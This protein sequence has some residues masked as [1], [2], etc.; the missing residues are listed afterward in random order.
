MAQYLNVSDNEPSGGPRVGII[1][2]LGARKRE[3]RELMEKESEYAMAMRMV[4]LLVS[5][6]HPAFGMT[7]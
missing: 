7:T 5:G 4:N 3:D 1:H 2:R 6:E